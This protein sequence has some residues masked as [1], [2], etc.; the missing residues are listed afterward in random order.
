[1]RLILFLFACGSSPAVMQPQPDLA[2]AAQFTWTTQGSAFFASYCVSCHT[3]G[4][5]A[6]Q[7]DFA[8][9]DQVMANAAHIRCG[10][11]V[12]KQSGCGAVPASK[13][14]PIG[15]GPK[16]SDA[17]RSAIVAWIDAGMPL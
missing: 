1:M 9:Y 13:Q 8:Q 4:G 16:P 7:Q 10:V 5:Q 11:A 3:P 17:E 15:S 12:T 2:Q 6:Q 14:F